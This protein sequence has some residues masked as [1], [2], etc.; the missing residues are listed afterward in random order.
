MP[1]LIMV[2]FMNEAGWY[3]TGRSGQLQ[4]LMRTGAFVTG[5][6][7]AYYVLFRGTNKQK[8]ATA[9]IALGYTAFSLAIFF[10]NY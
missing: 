3:G 2:T 1:I 6:G 8:L 4:A 9:L 5:F 10:D 7:C